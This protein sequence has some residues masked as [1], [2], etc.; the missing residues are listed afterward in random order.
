MLPTFTL[1]QFLEMISR[2]NTT[3]WPLQ[4]VAYLLGAVA[5]ILAIRMSSYSSKA[6]LAI[7]AL[8]WL[9]VGIVFNWAFF[10]PLYPMAVLFVVLFAI[11]GVMLAFTGLSRQT[12][13]FK[14]RADARSAVGALLVV[15]SMLGYPAIEYLL[16]R[17]FPDLLPFGLVPCPM[18]VFTLGILLWADEKPPWYVI[19]IPIL[20]SL[21]GVIPIWKGIVEDIGLV[22]AGLSA[23]FMVSRWDLAKKGILA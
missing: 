13:T 6:I 19:A 4:L 23:I 11:E 12:L 8:F 16:G 5:V 9:W 15:Y 10:S 2:Y 7:L 3:F 18:T 20:Y 21:S 22:A 17:G 1:E 14:P